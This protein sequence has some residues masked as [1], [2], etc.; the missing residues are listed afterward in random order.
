MRFKN[1]PGKALGRK[2]QVNPT[3]PLPVEDPTAVG[4]VPWKVHAL[5]FDNIDLARYQPLV[6]A[7]KWISDR[8]KFDF[9]VT[10]LQVSEP[11]GYTFYSEGRVV[12]NQQD[13]PKA[14]I[15]AMPVADSYAFFWNTG[16]NPPLQAGSTWGVSTGIWKGGIQR[17]YAT[18]PVDPWWYSLEPYG[19]F[20]MRASQIW[21]HEVINCIS[22]KLTVDPYNLPALA[23][24]DGLTEAADYEG[25]RLAKLTEEHY[26]TYVKLNP[27]L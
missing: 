15:D 9:Q 13:V 14:V 5:V 21:V 20:Q 1:M 6:E 27:E 24:D 3:P 4:R 25:S 17:P 8:T 16:A 7:T 22:C 12:V 18:V 10:M 11:H 26:Q 19:G 23:A 2:K